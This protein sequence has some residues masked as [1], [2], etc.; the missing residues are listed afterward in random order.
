M[1]TPESTLDQL[2]VNAVR[3]LATAPRCSTA[4]FT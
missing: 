3:A 4:C 1:T 2:C